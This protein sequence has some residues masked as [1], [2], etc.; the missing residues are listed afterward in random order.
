MTD[1]IIDCFIHL[2]TLEYTHDTSSPWHALFKNKHAQ[3]PIM[4]VSCSP[5]AP[6]IMFPLLMQSSSSWV[7]GDIVDITQVEM[8]DMETKGGIMLD[9][10]KTISVH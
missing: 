1:T 6:L 2:I 5:L 7:L 4:I 3:C 8:Y 9:F 10:G